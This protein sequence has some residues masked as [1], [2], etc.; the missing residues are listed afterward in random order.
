M[1]TGSQAHGCCRAEHVNHYT[2]TAWKALLQLS[3]TGTGARTTHHA[4]R[5]CFLTCW[6]SLRG[7]GACKV[8]SSA[9]SSSI[10]MWSGTPPGMDRRKST[11]SP[12]GVQPL[13]TPEVSSE[14]GLSIAPGPPPGFPFA[15]LAAQ[16]TLKSLW[17]PKQSVR[18]PA[19]STHITLGD[20]SSC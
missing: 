3:F 5:S 4:C 11:K 19:A 15:P 17:P 10:H 20:F 14:T 13:P 18:C 9:C 16:G 6:Q 12:H 8:L 2:C 1:Y 7:L